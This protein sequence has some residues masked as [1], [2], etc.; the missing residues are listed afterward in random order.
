M[1][2][3]HWFISDISLNC[4]IVWP[5]TWL[6]VRV[7]LLG[8]YSYLHMVLI[9]SA[10]LTW[11]RVFSGWI[12]QANSIPKLDQPLNL[13]LTLNPVIVK[14][15]DFR[16]VTGQWQ[17]LAFPSKCF[18]LSHPFLRQEIGRPLHLWMTAHQFGL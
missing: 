8:F 10:F 9:I 4:G 12:D 3:L 18:F 11:I 13:T 6:S 5:E 16:D 7:F 1:L 17:S 15:R 2:V 14:I